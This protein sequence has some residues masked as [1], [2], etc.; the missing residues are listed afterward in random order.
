MSYILKAITSGLY[1]QSVSRLNFIYTDDLYEAHFFEQQEVQNVLKRHE[2]ELEIIPVTKEL[3]Q[4]MQAKI[5][6]HKYDVERETREEST[7]H[8]KVLNDLS[9][10]RERLDFY[11]AKISKLEKEFSSTLQEASSDPYSYLV[12]KGILLTNQD[13]AFPGYNT[14]YDHKYGYFDHEMYYLSDEEQAVFEAK[15]FVQDCGV[16]YYAIVSKKILPDDYNYSDGIIEG[17]EFCLSDVMYC[18]ANIRGKIV[19]NFLED[20]VIDRDEEIRLLNKK[21]TKEITKEMTKENNAEEEN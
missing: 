7:R 2:S 9:E 1:I 21:I 16:S 8:L 19:E 14:S 11:S 20:H 13:E 18:I 4:S 12:D 5:S 17:E 6:L 15:D 3:V 10:R